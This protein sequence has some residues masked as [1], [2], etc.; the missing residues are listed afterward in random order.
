MNHAPIPPAT[1][2]PAAAHEALS[3]FAA[4]SGWEQRARLLLQWGERLEA[5]SDAEAF[6]LE[7]AGR[8]ARR[9][10][11]GGRA[12]DDQKSPACSPPARVPS[13]CQAAGA[14]LSRMNRTEPSINRTFTPLLW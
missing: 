14:M 1:T 13:A 4:C 5:L 8:V 9:A 2:L 3:A 6:D 10:R 7:H 12:G 11:A